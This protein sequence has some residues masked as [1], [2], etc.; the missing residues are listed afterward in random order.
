MDTATTEKTRVYSTGVPALDTALGCGGYP[1]GRVTELYGFHGGGK[2]A[3]ALRAVVECQRRG[4]TA[5]YIDADRRLDLDAARGAGVQ[6]DRLLVSQPEGP[7]QALEIAETLAR[8]GSVDLLVVSLAD[9]P[10]D[11]EAEPGLQARLVLQ[12][13]RK[14]AGIAHR[15]GVCVAFV[16]DLRPAPVFQ[17]SPLGAALKFYASVRL[18]VRQVEGRTRVK[19]VKNKC[20]APFGVAEFDLTRIER[21][22][23]VW[24]RSAVWPGGDWA[25]RVCTVRVRT[26]KPTTIANTPWSGRDEATVK[27][28]DRALGFCSRSCAEHQFGPA[29]VAELYG[30]PS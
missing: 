25:C 7:E 23:R 29:F 13:L 8:S 24:P 10:D 15:T 11:P 14:L 27:P 18:D 5:A 1:R 16:H 12:A 3:L 4:E 30:D 26:Y 20:G 9:W 28:A 21:F 17:P 22:D 2:R 19:V 6:I